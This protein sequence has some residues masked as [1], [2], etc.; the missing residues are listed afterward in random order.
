MTR[1][2]GPAA[3]VLYALLAVLAVLVV[4]VPLGLGDQW[5]FAALTVAGAV[6]LASR[7]TRPALLT[8]GILSL[9]I[10]TRYI[11]WRTT[12]TLSFDSPLETVLG[13]GL[14][15]AELYAWAILVLGL[16]QTAW[17]L[18]R[19]NVAI[20]GEPDSWPV[21]DVFIPTYNESLAIVRTTVFA[22]LDMDYPPDRFR[23][24]ILDD[25]RRAEFQ[26]FAREVGCG[27][28][29][30]ADNNHAKAG[31]LNTAMRK[32]NG[33]LVAIFD[34]DHV[35]T[36]AFLQLS[37]GWF[38][39]DARL[40]LLQTPHHMYSPD[41]V[42]RNLRSVK[43]QPGEG[44]LFYG[45]IQKGNDLWNAAFFCGSCAIIRRD[46]LSD[47]GGFAFETVT[48][49]A[50]TA[51]KLQRRGWN[52]AYLDS[53]LAA[54]LATE[55]LVLHIGQR[56]RWARGMTQIL[57]IDNPLMGR[58]LN[59]PQRLCYL[60]AMLHFQFPLPR[61]VFLTSPLAYLL[62]GANIIH[63]SASMIFAY[64][65]PH[66]YCSMV[67][68][69]LTHGPDRRPFWSEIY[70]TLIAFHLVRP[71]VVTW[72]QPRKGKFN[73]TDKGDTL[74]Q[75]FFDRQAVRPHLLC[76]ALVVIGVIWGAVK[77]VFY[78]HL[79]DIQGDTFA[80]NAAWATFSLLI[81][82]AAVS[83]AYESRQARRFVR[84]PANLPC[85]IHFANGHILDA[86]TEEISM[87]GLTARL[88]GDILADISGWQPTHLSM[89]MAD[90]RLTLP[91]QPV[92]QKGGQIR[93]RFP[94]LDLRQ[95][96]QLV[97]AV[98]GRAD[99][100]TRATPRRQVSALTAFK[101]IVVIAFVTI[102][103]LFRLNKAERRA[104]AAAITLH[105]E[106]TRNF[107]PE[108]ASR[109]PAL[110]GAGR[111]PLAA[112][113]GALA[114][115]LFAGLLLGP[116]AAFAQ[117]PG[118]DAAPA[119]Q[120]G[121]SRRVM[122]LRDLRILR[123]IRLE[124]TRGEIGIPFGMRQD[125]V[126]TGA[127]LVLNFASS[128]AM[129]ADLSQLVVLLNDE[130]VQTIPLTQAE[131][132][133]RVLTIPVNPALFLPG[134]NRLN[135]RLV[136]HY[137]RDC[138]DPFHSSLWANVSN[139]R[140]WLDLDVQRL[141][142]PPDLARLPRPL[143]DPGQ[144]GALVLPFVFATAPDNAAL[145][146]AAAIAGWMGSEASYRGFDFPPVVGRLPRGDAVVFLRAGQSLPGLPLPVGGAQARIVAN[147]ADPFGQLL[148][149][150]GASSRELKL[151]AA[152]IAS[153]R[154][155]FRGP[156]AQ[157][158]GA[159]IPLYQP[160][161][162]PRWL[163]TDRPVALGELVTANT[164]QGGG[165][166]PGPLA[167]QFR[168]APD[169]FFWPRD[170]GF[171]DIDYRFPQADW[172]D[173][174]ASRLDVSLNGQFQRSLPLA[175]ANWWQSLF[176]N[177]AAASMTNDARVPLPRYDLY[178]QNELVFDYN[179]VL[180]NKQECTGTL[181]ENVRT[182]VLPTSTIDLTNAYHA[183]RMPDLA[184]FA[185]AGYPFTIQPDLARTAVVLG[186]APSMETIRAFLMLM[187]RFGDATGAP[188]TR[189]RV[190]A[191]GSEQQLRD[192]DVVVLGDTDL[193]A[194]N[195]LFADAPISGSGGR[196]N[197]V[198]GPAARRIF[199]GHN[200]FTDQQA[201]AGQFVSGLDGFQG[202]VG[203]ESPYG[204]D[205]SV[206]AILADDPALLPLLVQNMADLQINAQIGGDLSVFNGEGMTSYAIGRS[207][208]SGSLPVWVRI[209]YWFS[210]Y[211]L[212][213]AAGGLLIAFLVAGPVLLLLRRRAASRLAGDE[214]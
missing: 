35:P 16:L 159:R 17:P 80:L 42:Q 172:L 124:G 161:G 133:G 37:V 198:Q 193:A 88:P 92:S 101:D 69:S 202:L 55:R 21:V 162:A 87:G 183:L 34:C 81:L 127:R 107:V 191:D 19:R 174:R 114:A 213:L 109:S 104:E 26:A 100:W 54:G 52:T 93:L 5:I 130:V 186:R 43:D 141:R 105:E 15:A 173:T 212:L 132:A 9:I 4:T 25:G 123:P 18:E 116:Q 82:T 90:E 41:P 7:H 48:E 120:A 2:H 214:A 169:L 179:M 192:L 1:L 98:M 28:L 145:E 65:L 40:A 181:P 112:G 83:V 57:R 156:E 10:S 143:F 56:I 45:P 152:A 70:E 23:V 84:I 60:N 142:L 177:S 117:A 140:S 206:V 197:V 20:R 36:R 195:P 47:I 95:E 89:P 203:F 58:G 110:R 149:I 187:G 205:R 148:V 12:Q 158:G 189:V 185:N 175:R 64:A 201:E 27:Y 178:G 139:V 131:A 194:D 78:P 200:P 29:T 113:A 151:A 164:L 66:L 204:D 157:L 63:A 106:E 91:V 182:A 51:L 137:T 6:W 150:S 167:V 39:R 8:L 208:W 153:G 209:S 94:G 33:D 53:R 155:A 50:H 85:T 168:A 73:V 49:D 75:S 79:F 44:D 122:T 190:L 196:L 146:A 13:L 170:G 184:S 163:R 165:L 62:F 59:W 144:T 211:P 147:P 126:V 111:R 180:A 188:A 154:T 99:A 125:E 22:A 171:T 135:L 199:D 128:P 86:R 118:E 166:R 31:N 115:L 14:Y 96:R 72:F 77:L 121:T 38:Q 61:I 97:R 160:Y 30:R 136:G 67:A 68:G 3:W 108:P 129:L 176:G 32:T 134:D 119:G 74:E 210:Q 207:Y 11:F 138:E 24:F 103:R 102:G 46:A 76:I 71:T